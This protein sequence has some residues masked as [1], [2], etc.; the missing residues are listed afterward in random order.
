MISFS[1][2]ASPF[3]R[4]YPRIA[5]VIVVLFGLLVIAS[6]Y[7][8]WR[9]IVQMLPNS[10]PMQYATALSFV[11]CG[12]ALALMVK[13]RRAFPVLLA[14]AGAVLPV[15][16]LLEYA[17]RRDLGVDQVLFKPYFEF[18][19]AYPGRMSPL[20]AVCFVLIAAAVGFAATRTPTRPR[21][22]T[23]GVLACAVTVVGLMAVF[24]FL[25]GI[26]TAY[27]WGAYSGM[28]INTA[29][30]FFLLGT[31]L[32]AWAWDARPRDDD[33]FLRWLPVT[34]ALTLMVMIVFVSAVNMVALRRATFWRRHTI[35]VILAGH[36]FE[37]TLTDLQ[38]GARGYATQGDTSA[39]ASYLASAKAEPE[40]LGRLVELTKDNPS[41]QRRLSEVSA[42]VAD[43]LAYDRGLVGLHDREGAAGVAR[44]DIPAESRRL[45]GAARDLVRAFSQA[46][47]QLLYVRDAS[48]QTGASNATRLLIFSSVVASLVLLAANFFIGTA[49]RRRRRAEVEREKLI[50]EL[51]QAIEEVKT[52]SGMIPIC[53]WCKNIRS[54]QGYW[55]SVEQYVRAHT[56]ATFTHGICP[57][58]EAKFKADLAAGGPA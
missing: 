20:A 31:G 12:A 55:Q 57:V 19:T 32:L 26:D 35:E 16:S 54:D 39:L 13:G 37:E 48:E 10:A 36:A 24:G 4:R 14:S 9:G 38:R 50:S 2:G 52:L 27:T 46:E 34:G 22:T 3:T 15:L 11:L 56:D 5:G 6:W 41:Q 33:D 7:A 23:V 47:E 17:T 18:A 40:L 1:G 53:G 51:R 8:H 45:S 29:V 28:A 21:L 30:A 42:A 49:M 44:G 58:C 25:A 43:L